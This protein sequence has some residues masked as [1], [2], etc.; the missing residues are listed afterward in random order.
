MQNETTNLETTFATLIIGASTNPSRFSYK[1]TRMLKDYNFTAIPLG[2][3]TG[4]IDD[5]EI[6]TS[7]D[8]IDQDIDTITLYVGPKHQPGYYDFIL[9]LAPRRVIFNPGTENF[10]L[11]Q[12]LKAHN[13]KVVIACTLVM[14]STGQY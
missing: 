1:A 4:T 3:R 9:D 11:Y 10:E 5:I 6:I 2:L 12:L 8:Q 13:I 7:A 14:L